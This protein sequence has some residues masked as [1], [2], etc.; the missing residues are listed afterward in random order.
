MKYFHEQ[1]ADV[2]KKLYETL[3]EETILFYLERFE[4]IVSGNGGYFVNGKVNIFHKSH[5]FFI[6]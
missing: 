3:V 6:T 1:N 5:T 2:K 4:K